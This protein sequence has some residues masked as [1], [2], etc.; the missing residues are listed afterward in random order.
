[1]SRGSNI[2]ASTALGF[3]TTHKPDSRKFRVFFV[4][5]PTALDPSGVLARSP[6]GYFQNTGN[7]LFST[8]VQEQLAWTERKCGFSFDPG[9]VNKE[10]DVVVIPAANWLN[11]RVTQF[12][13]LADAVERLDLPVVMVGLGA[14]CPRGKDFP[15]VPPDVLRLVR[16]AAERSAVIG[17]RGSYSAQ[18]L[19]KYG[20]YNIAVIGCPSLYGKLTPLP[21][22][23][24]LAC[25][26]RFAVGGT[27]HSST[28]LPDSLPAD[29]PAVLQRSI[30]RFAY[31]NGLD[32]VYQSERPEIDYMIRRS[33]EVVEEYN[34]E[35]ILKYYG[36]STVTGWAEFLEGHG[37]VYYDTGSWGAAMRE[38]DFYFGSRLHGAIM[39]LRSGVPACLLTHDKRTIEIAEFAGIPAMPIQQAMPLSLG[40]LRECYAALDFGSW[41]DRYPNNLARYVDFL[42]ENHLPHVKPE[43]MTRN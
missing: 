26:N 25:P 29:S 9:A 40:R 20:I 7:L 28:L 35:N 15:E 3:T 5:L 42:D 11:E 16:S 36:A 4:S 14:Q 39:A 19:R 34:G 37:K 13:G 12:G 10:F 38:V 1:M 43:L 18:V 24:R 17:V 21:V 2:S 23:R 30:Y 32:V 6:K 8:A 33:V 41:L 31:E 27:G 22:V